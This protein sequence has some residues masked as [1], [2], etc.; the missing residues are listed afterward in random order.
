[1]P[2]HDPLRPPNGVAAPENR[3]ARAG[4]WLNPP[5]GAYGF[6]SFVGLSFDKKLP[7]GLAKTGGGGNIPLVVQ[8]VTSTDD[9]AMARTAIDVRLFFARTAFDFGDAYFN[10]FFSVSSLADEDVRLTRLRM[11][12]FAM[13]KG[14]AAGCF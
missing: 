11:L 1:M 3:G 8:P 13:I 10:M 9:I 7:L 6:A 2:Q 5:A 4:G 12:L 14:L